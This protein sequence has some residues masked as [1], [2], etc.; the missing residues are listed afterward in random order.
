MKVIK[1][2]MTMNYCPSGFFLSLHVANTFDYNHLTYLPALVSQIYDTF[3]F[4]F[5]VF[6]KV[7][8]AFYLSVYRILS[9]SK[10]LR[11]CSF[12]KVIMRD[13]NEVFII[14]HKTCLEK[15]H[16]PASATVTWLSYQIL[17]QSP[18]LFK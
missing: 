17:S 6:L 1:Q 7:C 4:S 2:Q 3:D 15:K 10:A 8:I 13:I 16:Y 11:A 5:C 9:M 14:S 18:H 12:L